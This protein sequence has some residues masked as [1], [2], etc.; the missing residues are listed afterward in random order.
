[1]FKESGSKI[2]LFHDGDEVYAEML[3]AIASATSRIWMESYIFAYD[4]IGKEFIQALG[5]QA[6]KGV[7]VCVHLD[8]AGNLFHGGKQVGR[9]LQEVGVRIKFFHRWSLRKPLRY[10]RR[11]HRKLLIIDEKKVYFG[12]FN[13]QREN[14]TALMGTESWRDSHVRITEQAMVAQAAELFAFFW[15]SATQKVESWGPL[16]SGRLISNHSRRLRRQLRITLARTLRKTQHSLDLATPYLVPDQGL[17]KI[18]LNLARRGVRVR[19][20]LPSH[21]DHRFVQWAAKASYG[22]LLRAGVMIYEYQP[23]ML[24]CKIILVDGKTSLIGTANMDYRSM[25]DNYE[26]LLL[27]HESLVCKELAENFAQ[28]LLDSIQVTLTGWSRRDWL[29]RVLEQVGWWFRRLL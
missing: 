23:K 22:K 16:D 19:L 18:L 12:G 27:T 2:K 3:S 21:G 9:D 13:I 28:D 8:A 4:D 29:N 17:L 5:A 6:K 24:H 10:N 20:L 14:S 7:D 25:L 1:M 15:G 26:L 11:N